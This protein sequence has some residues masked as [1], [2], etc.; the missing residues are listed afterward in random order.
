MGEVGCVDH[1]TKAVPG[2]S[3]SMAST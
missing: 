1:H 3:R 2:P